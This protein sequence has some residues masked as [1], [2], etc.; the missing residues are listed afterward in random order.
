MSERPLNEEGGTGVEENNQASPLQPTKN[1]EKDQALPPQPTKIEE[2]GQA[3]PPRSTKTEEKDQ[4]SRSR[5]RREKKKKQRSKVARINV[6]PNDTIGIGDISYIVKKPD[7][8]KLG[9]WLTE[10]AVEIYKEIEFIYGV[11]KDYCTKA[12]CPSMTAGRRF[13]YLWADGDKY[14]Q[15]V[16]L[17]A[18][19][20]VKKLM[21]WV[22]KGLDPYV[23]KIK[24]GSAG[25]YKGDREW[26]KALKNIFK[27]LFRVYAHIYH[28]HMKVVE[29]L[30]VMKHLN[31]SFQRFIFFVREFKLISFQHMEPLADLIKKI[32]YTPKE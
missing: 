11:L 13:E 8:E 1:E 25:E 2:K 6:N 32:T 15:P 31:T 10:N 24:N 26:R 16:K 3:S 22:Q 4:A 7:E 23:A 27:R 12:Q 5:S 21:A 29:E 14:I 28:S 30:G 19:E 18:P 17:P 9:E 20:Y